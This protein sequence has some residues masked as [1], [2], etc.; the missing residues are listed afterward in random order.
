MG[1]RK[2]YEIPEPAEPPAHRELCE[3]AQLPRLHEGEAR[4][5]ARSIPSFQGNIHQALPHRVC[6]WWHIYVISPKRRSLAQ[7]KKDARE[8]HALRVK[9]EEGL[10]SEDG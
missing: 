4:K 10:A 7:R 9:I 8:D 5:E 1:R 2:R 3:P 6:G